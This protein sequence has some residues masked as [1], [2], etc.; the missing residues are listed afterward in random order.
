MP[1]L[2][3]VRAE[4]ADPDGSE[5][6]GASR[7]SGEPQAA[8][9]PRKG[10]IGVWVQTAAQHVRTSRPRFHPDSSSAGSPDHSAVIAAVQA[11]PASG[12]PGPVRTP[13]SGAWPSQQQ[14]MHASP[15][16]SPPAM[17]PAPAAGAPPRQP[18]LQLPQ[19]GVPRTVQEHAA[20]AAARAGAQRVAQLQAS[21]GVGASPAGRARTQH[22]DTG[23]PAEV[24]TTIRPTRTGALW[25]PGAPQDPGRSA[26]HA[27]PGSG[28]QLSSGP[29][30][31]EEED[32]TTS[33]SESPHRPISSPGASISQV[34]RPQ[35]RPGRL[36]HFVRPSNQL[37]D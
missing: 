29:D 33:E 19:R 15:G 22:V 21:G 12:G 7:A 26:Q 11:S 35:G 17:S 23:P 18:R 9:S 13:A 3:Y 32:L 6:T 5:A 36:G 27:P 37:F 10:R 25:Q 24:N 1:Y 28:R 16:G 20:A 34:G 30:E 2:P 8:P 14:R 4:S 31:D